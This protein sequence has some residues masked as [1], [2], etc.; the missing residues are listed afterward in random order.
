MIFLFFGISM[1]YRGRG[2]DAAAVKGTR[3]ELALFILVNLAFIGLPLAYAF[4]SLFGFLDYD[5]PDLADIAGIVGLVLAFAIRMKA[6]LDL[7]DSFTISPG[8]RR[9][10]DM[11][12]TGIY[13]YVRHPMYLSMLVWGVA[14]PLVLQ[15]YLLGFLPL[16]SIVAF[17]TVRLPSEEDIL[18]KE[19][20]DRYREY[21]S[22]TGGLLPRFGR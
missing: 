15:N 10:R 1:L 19:F 12:T 16:A 6:H 7:G 3:P 8:T 13:A 21:M 18:L 9:E 22:M 2:R 17:L 5:L 4:T 20:G 14:T 11:V